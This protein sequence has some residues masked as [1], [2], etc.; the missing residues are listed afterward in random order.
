VT[1]E[2]SDLKNRK[3]DKLIKQNFLYEWESALKKTCLKELV[4]LDFQQYLS[5]MK[6]LH[7]ISSEEPELPLSLKQSQHSQKKEAEY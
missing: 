1:I 5:I 2:L 7:F 6:E 4:E 3:R